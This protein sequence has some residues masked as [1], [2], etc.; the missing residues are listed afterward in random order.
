MLSI[1]KIGDK[2]KY[3]NKIGIVSKFVKYMG[4]YSYGCGQYRR[5]CSYIAVTVHLEDGMRHI[6][7]SPRNL[8]LCE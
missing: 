8:E 6:N 1:L 4:G 3:K 7:V 5:Q 2:V